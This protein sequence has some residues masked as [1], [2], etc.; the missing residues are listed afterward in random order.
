M[1]E[2]R[3][4]KLDQD[5]ISQDV[6]ANFTCKHPD[7]DD[8]IHNDACTAMANGEGVTYVLVNDDEY[9]KK[10]VKNILAFATIQA[11]SLYYNL[12]ESSEEG[13][14]NA[15]KKFYSL[16]CVEIKY[17]AIHKAFQKSIAAHIDPDKYYSTIFFE[18]L[19]QDLYEMSC[20]IIGFQAIFLR[21]NQNGYKLYKRKKFT[22]CSNYIISYEECDADNKCKPM[23]L[24]IAENIEEIFG[25]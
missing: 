5:H 2:L 6:I 14:K 16:P 21:A 22:D 10:E 11:T 17:F 25:C 8:F 7:F 18:Y 12:D 19:L 24:P 1:S 20:K 15:Y 4:F 23:L 9:Y 13:S 3:F